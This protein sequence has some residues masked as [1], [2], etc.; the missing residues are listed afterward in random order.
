VD[1]NGAVVLNR[2]IGD[3]GVVV[4]MRSLWQEVDGRPRIVD[5][6]PVEA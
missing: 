3:N 2:L 5:G 6:G 4:T 1:E